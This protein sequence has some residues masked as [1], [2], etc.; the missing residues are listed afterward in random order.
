MVEKLVLDKPLDGGSDGAFVMGL[1]SA[2]SQL[3]ALDS[4]SRLGLKPWPKTKPC[5]EILCNNQA[6]YLNIAL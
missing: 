4:S 2:Q 5:I 1:S 6:S 3:S